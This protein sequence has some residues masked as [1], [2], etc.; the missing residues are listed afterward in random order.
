MQKINKI[1]KY[2]TKWCGPCQAADRELDRFQLSHEGIDVNI[3]D[4]EEATEPIPS[5]IKSIPFYCFMDNQEVIQEH[6]G[7]LTKEGIEEVLTNIE[8]DE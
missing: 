4:V 5:N 3:I 6:T 1:V 2:G 7:M 8:K